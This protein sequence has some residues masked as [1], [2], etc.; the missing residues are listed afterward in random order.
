MGSEMC[1]RDSIPVVEIENILLTHPA[2]KEVALVPLPHERLGETAC[3]C[4]VPTPGNEIPTVIEMGA[5]L[6]VHGVATQFFPEAVRRCA[7]LPRTPSGKIDRT[8]LTQLASSGTATSPSTGREPTTETETTLLEIWR[9]VMP[10][11]VAG[12]DDNFFQV[13]GHSL[14]ATKVIA[15]SR[16]VFSVDLPLHVIFASPTVA[17]MATEIDARREPE[18]ALDALMADLEGMSDEEVARL[19]EEE[20]RPRRDDA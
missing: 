2:I 13:G 1:I 3:A 16:A 19:L 5:F 8:T 7:E 14:L 4:V 17:T 9:E 10:G 12:V 18:D 15:R 6:A 20:P 11:A